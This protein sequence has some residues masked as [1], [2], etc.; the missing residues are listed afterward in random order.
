MASAPRVCAAVET[1]LA[2][3]VGIISVGVNRENQGQTLILHHSLPLTSS[4]AQDDRSTK[5]SA[6]FLDAVN[7]SAF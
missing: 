2:V 1:R 4:Y 7:N 3:S 5:P 6:R